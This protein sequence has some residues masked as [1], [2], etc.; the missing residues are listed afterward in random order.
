MNLNQRLSEMLPTIATIDPQTV[1]NTELY[2]DVIDFGKVEQA[3]A[4]ALLG[5]MAAET[6]DFRFY[7]CDSDGSNA[8]LVTG[9]AATQLAA[10]A[11][12]NDNTQLAINVRDTDLLAS[13]KQ[14]G[15]FGLVTGGATGGPAAVIVQGA[16]RQGAATDNDLST[17]Q[18]IV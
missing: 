12:A 14:Y 18:Q 13:G 6:I 5:N 11:G 8:A 4:V 10:S 1:A 3:F 2:T 15:K 7:S 17:V 16:L 9:K